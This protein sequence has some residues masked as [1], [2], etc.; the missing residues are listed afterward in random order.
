MM[1][2]INNNN[3]GSSRQL[4]STM[5]Q[6][7]FQALYNINS[8]NLHKIGTIITDISQRGKLKFREFN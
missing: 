6:A 7:L 1:T 3:N 8:L 2:M 4:G 5:Y